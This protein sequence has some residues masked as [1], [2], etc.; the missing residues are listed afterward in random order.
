VNCVFYP[1]KLK[2]QPFFANISKSREEPRPPP[3]PP[4]RRPCAEAIHISHVE[5]FWK[6][7]LIGVLHFQ[8]FWH[9]LF[10][11]PVF[12]AIYAQH[13]K[14]HRFSES[15]SLVRRICI[16]TSVSKYTFSDP[17]S[18]LFV[19]CSVKHSMSTIGGL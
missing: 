16:H 2:K 11:H 6:M 3:A 13:F 9:W 1:S 12:A 19:V 8:T 17:G 5:L 14:R 4:F 7:M 15:E 18:L 10:L